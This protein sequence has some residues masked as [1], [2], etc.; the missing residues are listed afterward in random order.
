MGLFVHRQSNLYFLLSPK[1]YWLK[2]LCKA[3]VS[4]WLYEYTDPLAN[5]VI[6]ISLKS[7]HRPEAVLGRSLRDVSR[8]HQ[9]L[10]RMTNARVDMKFDGDAVLGQTLGVVQVLVDEDVQLS[11]VDVGGRK[12]G[13]V[14]CSGWGRVVRDVRPACVFPQ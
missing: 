12:T 10:E 5:Q 2:G 3:K 8:G 9:R 7:L 6:V 13:Q 14:I 11:H 1:I 4:F